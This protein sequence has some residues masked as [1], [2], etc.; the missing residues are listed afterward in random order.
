M[1][2]GKVRITQG[3]AEWPGQATV[4]AVD[5]QKAQRYDPEAVAV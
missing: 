2:P 5:G 1:V 4:A 3:R